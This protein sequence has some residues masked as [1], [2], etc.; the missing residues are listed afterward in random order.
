MQALVE[1]SSH[2][3]KPYSAVTHQFVSSFIVLRI[4]IDGM[5]LEVPVELSVDK[6]SIICPLKLGSKVTDN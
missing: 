4:A 3:R 2:V 5:Y 1:M 6:I